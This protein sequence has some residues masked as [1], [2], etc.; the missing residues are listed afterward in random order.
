MFAATLRDYALDFALC[1]KNAPPN[2][3]GMEL[4]C[5]YKSARGVRRNR[6]SE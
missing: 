1:Y 2:A 4:S 6:E 3:H 5:L